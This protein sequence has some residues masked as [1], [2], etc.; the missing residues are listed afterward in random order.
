MQYVYL[1]SLDW[2]GNFSWRL[3]FVDKFLKW[4]TYFGQLKAYLP[5]MSRTNNNEIIVLFEND[6]SEVSPTFGL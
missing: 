4:N 2:S 5:E 6:V 1:Y 3:H